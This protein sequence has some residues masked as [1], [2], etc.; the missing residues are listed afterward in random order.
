[1]TTQGRRMKFFEDSEAKRKGGIK[2]DA[3]FEQ[4][5]AIVYFVV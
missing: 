2:P 1:M 4:D 3:I 5:K